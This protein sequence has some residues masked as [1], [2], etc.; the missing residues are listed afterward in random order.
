MNNK[1]IID[2]EELILFILEHSRPNM[3]IK[4]LNKLAYFLEFSYIFEFQKPL[5]NVEYAAINMGPVLNDYK[6]IIKKMLKKRKIYKN[7]EADE[8]LEDYLPLKKPNKLDTNLAAFLQQVLERYE[9]LSPKQLEDLSHG[10]DSYNIT[11]HEN[12][13]KMGGTIDK[14]LGLLDYSLAVDDLENADA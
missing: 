12:K 5:T 10:L 3:G 1:E 4:K 13:K 2:I 14:D 7:A 11:V 9:K 6:D 8:G